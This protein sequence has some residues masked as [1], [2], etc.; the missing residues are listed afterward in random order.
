AACPVHTDAGAYVTAIA[1][2]RYREAY[3]IARAP[4]PFASICGRVCA[5]PCESACRRGTLDAPIAIRAL[6]RFVTEQFG[7]E[8]FLANDAWHEAHGPV[9]PATEPS[10]GVIGG[11]PAGLA[12]AHDLRLAGHPVTVYEANARLGGMMVL[13]IP[14]YRLPRALISREIEAIL[15]LG[16]EARTGFRVGTDATVPEL[17]ERHDALFLAVGTGRGRDLQLPGYELDGVL[18]AIEFLLNVN[19][20]FHVD[21]GERV[22]VVGG[23][24]VAFDAARTA[25][26]AAAGDPA[27][28]S[29]AQSGDVV[30]PGPS[31]EDARRGMTTTLDVARAAVRAG[32]RDV[33]VFALESPEEIPADPEEIAE[34]E[35]EGITIVYRR[36]PHRFVGEGGRVTGLETIA[37]E[38][39]FDE[40][41]RFAPTFFPDTEAVIPA[42]SIVLAVGQSADLDLLDSVE[43]E[44]NPQ[45]N[46][47]VDPETL[48][49]THPR[50][51]AGGD[52][53]KGPR[54]LI[55]AVADGRRA[56]AGI[57]AALGGA[58]QANGLPSLGTTPSD[59]RVEI[60]VRPGFRRLD[61]GYDAI[62]RVDVPTTPTDRRVGFAEVEVGYDEIDAQREALR[63]LRCFDNIMLDPALCILCG[64]CVDVC[65]TDCITIARADHIGVGVAAQSALLLDEDHCIRCALCVNRCPPGALS[66]VHARVESTQPERTQPERTQPERTQEVVA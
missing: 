38:S 44:R 11:G 62:P 28:A 14:E 52:V 66:M 49:T 47:R 22:V 53:A 43:V 56:A 55:D 3:L 13:G 20:G 18:R 4:N 9:P 45:G 36:G 10:V 1:E 6:K 40:Q 30:G 34:A 16:V 46:L 12:A 29:G 61:S 17:L 65:P 50:I 26:R 60:S 21:L 19:Q 39:V 51:W 59:V 35:Q 33:T 57:H 24:N 23:G 32:V 54:N 31:A 41:G 48:Q 5:A 42:D 37:V 64:L 27:S 2:G 25:L 63:C 8:S 7:V 15:E 58:T